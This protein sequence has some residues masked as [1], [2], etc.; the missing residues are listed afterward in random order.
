MRDSL[1]RSSTPQPQQRLSLL[2]STSIIVG[3]IIG[4]GLYET[5]PTIGQ[6]AA[7][8]AVRTTEW[9]SGSPANSLSTNTANLLG[10][11]AVATIWIIGGITA[12]F[13]AVCYAELASTYPRD[14]GNYVFLSRAFGREA[15]FAFAWIEFWIIRPGNLGAV[16]FVFAN[17]ASRLLPEP[18]SPS[19]QAVVAAGAVL[20]LTALNLA[21]VRV[22][23]STQ[24][25]LTLAKVVGLI[26]V[27]LVGLAISPTARETVD[28]ELAAKAGAATQPWTTRSPDLALAFILLMFAYG[29][30]S[31]MSYVAA[32]VRNPRRNISRALMLGTLAVAVLYVSF[33]LAM[34]KGLGVQGFFDSK[35]VAADVLGQAWATIGSRFISVL[36][37]VSCLGAMNGMIFTG[38]RIYY[39]L[40]T[41]HRLF[42]W[43]GQWSSQRDVPLRSLLVQAVVASLLIIAFGRSEN[44]FSRLVVFTGPFFWGFFMLVGLSLFALRQSDADRPR[45]FRVPFYP[46]TP[47]LFVVSSGWMTASAITYMQSN[48]AWEGL[49]AVVV[50][51]VGLFVERWDRRRQDA[52]PSGLR[53]HDSNIH[54]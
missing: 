28:M 4:S 29:G 2:D 6:N 42:A 38:S 31:D 35:A 32:E 10:V 9:L 3:I 34:V 16:A 21:D 45:P 51:V 11:A 30:W 36:I 52:A 40:G 14:G 48:P 24:N 44:G 13:G 19:W 37:C 27:I 39:A 25:V 17:Y 47:L 18:L 41:E 46:F 12:W 49:W 50:V 22:G 23:K 5:S 1:I 20:V 53:L 43:L 15:G 33:N 54:A 8:F 7:L 26:L